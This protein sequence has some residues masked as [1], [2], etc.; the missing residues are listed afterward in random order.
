LSRDVVADVVINQHV[1]ITAKG[2]D[3]HGAVRCAVDA[4]RD[5]LRPVCVDC[6]KEGMTPA[7]D[8]RDPLTVDEA[9]NFHFGFDTEWKHLPSLHASDDLLNLEWIQSN[10]SD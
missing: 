7:D 8:S 9:K 1:P 3:K 10:G 6:F 2:Y 5:D 4:N